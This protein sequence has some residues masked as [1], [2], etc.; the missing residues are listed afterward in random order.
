MSLDTFL[1]PSTP[2]VEP[3]Y[4]DANGDAIFDPAPVGTYDVYVNDSTDSRQTRW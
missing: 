3:I 1:L 4:T 2:Y